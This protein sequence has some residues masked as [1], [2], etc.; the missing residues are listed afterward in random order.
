MMPEP[1]RAR[2]RELMSQDRIEY[3]QIRL[4]S[5][6]PKTDICDYHAEVDLYGLGPGVYPKADGPQPPFHPHCYCLVAPMIALIN[7]KP[8][9]NPK[10]ER[11]F[12][13]SLPAKEARGRRREFRQAQPDSGREGE[14]Q[15][16]TMRER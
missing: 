1:F 16:S 8:K 14:Y 2:A 9:F 4:S 10:A 6:H 11:A 5:K 7:P 13:E 15:G 12:L 3:V